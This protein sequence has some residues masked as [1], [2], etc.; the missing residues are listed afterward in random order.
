MHSHPCPTPRHAGWHYN[1]V[2]N[3][4]LD[5]VVIYYEIDKSFTGE[6]KKFHTKPI[7]VHHILSD[8]IE[9]GTQLAEP[10]NLQKELLK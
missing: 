3:E 7:I 8:I 2:E 6:E 4:I 5:Q 9:R 1:S 10:G